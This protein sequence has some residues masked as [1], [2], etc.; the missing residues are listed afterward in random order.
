[1]SENNPEK[2]DAEGKLLFH[3]CF[4]EFGKDKGT[5]AIQ[6]I[7]LAGYRLGREDKELLDDEEKMRLTD[8]QLARQDDVDNDIWAFL[9]SMCPE[10]LKPLE[11]WDIHLVS[12]VRDAVIE[13]F[14]EHYGEQFNSY[15]FYPYILE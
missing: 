10:G 2:Y 1:M 3:K 15:T 4:P 5:Q 13:A 11:D 9:R 7:F 8:D 6:E 12:I 14:Q